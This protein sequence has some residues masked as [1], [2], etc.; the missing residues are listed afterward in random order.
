LRDDCDGHE[1][2]PVQKAGTYRSLKGVG[3]ICKQNEQYGGRQRE[4]RPGC[5]TA[6]IAAAHQAN[7]KSD[8]TAGG[9]RKELTQCDEI[10]EGRLVDPSPPYHEF[11]SEITDVSD[12]SAKTAFA[13]LG[14]RGQHLSGRAGSII[15]FSRSYGH[16]S[17]VIPTVA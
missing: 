9:T 5:K 17:S 13:E 6:E 1:L 12:R 3:T 11:F 8:L 14:E 7:G 2:E 16:S 10:G 4:G 15:F